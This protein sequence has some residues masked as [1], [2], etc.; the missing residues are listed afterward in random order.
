MG[1]AMGEPTLM[2]LDKSRSR[3]VLSLPA[4]F[5]NDGTI[6]SAAQATKPFNSGVRTIGTDSCIAFL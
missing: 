2:I 6:V 1:D 3:S 5:I 4:I